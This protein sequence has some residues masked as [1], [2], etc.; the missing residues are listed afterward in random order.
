MD[1]IRRFE[2]YFE[3]MLI[4]VPPLVR[5]GLSD[6]EILEQ[7]TPPSDMEN[8]WRFFDWKHAKNVAL[9]REFNL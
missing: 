1:C 3:E 2:S 8:W 7:V 5:D 4:A 9:I 6:E